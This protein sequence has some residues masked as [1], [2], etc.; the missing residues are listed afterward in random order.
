VHNG[1]GG[2]HNGRRFDEEEEEEDAMDND[3]R[4]A[5]AG[6]IDNEHVLLADLTVDE[7]DDDF[8]TYL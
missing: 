2:F 7:T 1:G 8:M 4:A 6:V 5:S 3:T